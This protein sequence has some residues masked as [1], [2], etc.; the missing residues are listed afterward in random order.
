MTINE[1]KKA[2]LECE[3]IYEA[4]ELFEEALDSAP[5]VNVDGSGIESNG[6][7]DGYP[8]YF[9]VFPKDAFVEAFYEED[10]FANDLEY[11][12]EI[13]E[14]ETLMKY[15]LNDFYFIDVFGDR[16]EPIIS[17]RDFGITDEQKYEVLGR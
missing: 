17:H 8:A 1:F 16:N 9:C 10:F 2:V 11:W 12:L 6:T 13:G 4:L 15:C 14:W 3:D 7:I 5:S